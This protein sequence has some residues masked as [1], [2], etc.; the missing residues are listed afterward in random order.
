MGIGSE[1]VAGGGLL[2]ANRGD[3]VTGEDVVDVLTMIGMH[4][5]KTPQPLLPPVPAVDEGMTL[6][7]VTGIHPEIGELADVGIAHDLEG[8]GRERCGVVGRPLENDRLIPGLV[9]DYRWEV[10]RARQVGENRVE[11]GLDPLV[12]EGRATQ[13][14][15]K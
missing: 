11:K 15:N 9:P 2:E 8:K 5:K 1:G 14:R 3:D 10:D 7:G 6:G 13:H 12:L 4:A